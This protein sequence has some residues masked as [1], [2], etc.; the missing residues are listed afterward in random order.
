MAHCLRV[1]WCL[2]ALFAVSVPSVAQARK[3]A[4]V[5]YQYEQVWSAAVRM[6]RVDLAL[7]INDRDESIG[8]ILFEYREQNR[9][10]PGSVEL[11]RV[12][13]EGRPG[14]RIVLQIPAMPSYIEQM[15]IDRLRRK[16]LDEF[17]EPPPPPRREPR[18]E[19][20][21][22]DDSDEPGDRNR[23]SRDEDRPRDRDG[24][25]APRNGDR[26]P[27]RDGNGQGRRR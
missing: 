6:V 2:L 1:S 14:V 13:V 26:S 3:T 12:A 24:D 8:Y 16:L 10:Y 18:E 19:Q 11:V 9:A 5:A 21:R 22:D 4:D 25:R 15:L 7:P 20:P 23:G 17:G 27:R